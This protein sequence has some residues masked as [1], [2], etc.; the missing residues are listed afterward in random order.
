MASSSKSPV[1][2]DDSSSRTEDEKYFHALNANVSNFVS[3]KLSGKENYHLWKTQ[4]LCLMKAHYMCGLVDDECVNNLRASSGRTTKQYNKE[5]DNLLKGWIFGSISEGVLGTVAELGS[6]EEVWRKLKRIHAPFTILQVE[7]GTDGAGVQLYRTS[8]HH[9]G[10]HSVESYNTEQLKKLREATKKGCWKDAKSI[11]ENGK[12]LERGPLDSEQNRVLHLAVGLIGHNDFI[13]DLLQFIQ[14]REDQSEKTRNLD[15]RS[16]VLEMR[17][18]NGSTALHVAAIV[19]NRFAAELLV[20]KNKNLLTIL[21]DRGRTPLYKAYFYMQLDTFIYLEDQTDRNETKNDIIYDTKMGVR[22]LVNAISAK[23]YSKAR[24]LVLKFPH[25]AKENDEALMAMARTFPDELDYWEKLIYPCPLRNCGDK[26]V[27]KLGLVFIMCSSPDSKNNVHLGL[28]LAK[29]SDVYVH[30]VKD[31]MKKK[32]EWDEAKELLEYV[33]NAIGNKRE[34]YDKVILEAARQNAYQVVDEILYRLPDVIY[35]SDEYG[36]D[37][38]QLA[39]IHRSEKIYNLIN[40]IDEIKNIYRTCTDS[41][42][43]NI[44]HLVGRLA[45]SHELNSLKGAALQLQRD[46]QWRE[47]LKKFMFPQYITKENIFN[48]TPAM[49]FTR[50]HKDLMKGGEKWMKTTAKSCSITAGLITTVVFAA[51]ITVPGGNNQE[52]GNPLFRKNIAFIMFAAANAISLFASI[53]ALLV[54]LSILTAS[55]AEQDF[56]ISLPRRLISGF[57]AL[58]LSTTAM[59]VSFSAILYLMFCDKKSWMM[60]LICGLA[61]IPITSFVALQY[62]LIVDLYRSTYGCIFDEQTSLCSSRSGLGRILG[63]FK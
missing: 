4:M 61:F 56:L 62:S 19:G 9:A 28:Y 44:L 38:I 34:I 49:V 42:K 6:A 26:I 55:F 45:P 30:L 51:A 16:L 21:D 32:T 54:F 14:K 2:D 63:Y 48:E 15:G 36:Y 18:L 46:L 22:L 33:C 52:T 29:V 43:N 23:K 8:V 17:N 10:S 20:N 47:E 27:E 41:Y 11:L 12:D 1:P 57:C 39:I 50:E 24:Q 31:I 13:K 53:T 35:N 40:Q 5:Y 60:G 58:L 3:V 7:K 25:F 59:M 37:I